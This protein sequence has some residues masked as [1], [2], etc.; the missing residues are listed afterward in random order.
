[1]SASTLSLR[2]IGH[3]YGRLAALDAVELE[4]RGPGVTGLLGVNGA[5]KSTLL[6][7]LAGLLRPTQGEARLLGEPC[8]APSLRARVG[9]LAQAP[10]FWPWMTGFELVELSATLHGL[11]PHQARQRAGELLN[12]LGLHAAADR[13]VGGYSGGMRQ[14]LGLAQALVGQP[15]V[16]LLDEPVAALDPVGRKEV[17]AL[18]AELG[19]TTTVFFSSHILADVERVAQRVI[20]LHEGRVRV[21]EGVESLRAQALRPVFHLRVVGD[22]TGL[23]TTLRA[24]P[25]VAA[26]EQPGPEELHVRVLDVPEAQR[27]L[28]A[29]VAAAGLGLAALSQPAPTLEDIFLSR[30]RA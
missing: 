19:R 8:G 26:V 9:V 28:P 25:W 24:C 14:R 16:L 27:A 5:G 13:R 18:L 2:G 20:V 15:A 7:I 11:R 4:L 3:R 10:A 17:L 30:V 1:M 21:D 6:R 12:Q 22:P 29:A 23:V